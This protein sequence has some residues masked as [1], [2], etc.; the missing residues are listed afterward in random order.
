MIKF[1][2]IYKYI[3]IAL[4]FG[5]FGFIKEYHVPK[6][7]TLAILQVKKLTDKYIPSV[8][9]LPNDIEFGL[10]PPE[11]KFK[12][13]K[14]HMKGELV[15]FL[16]PIRIENLSIRLKTYSLLTGNYYQFIEININQPNF[17]VIIHSDDTTEVGSK[18]LPTTKDFINKINT[19]INPKVTKFISDI[20]I[21]NLNIIDAKITMEDTSFDFLSKINRLNLNIKNHPKGISLETY[22]R[23]TLFKRKSVNTFLKNIELDFKLDLK[24]DILSLS[25]VK[26]QHKKSFIISKGDISFNL[27]KSAV[28]KLNVKARTH[29][30]LASLRQSILT[31]F[32][33]HSVPKINGI[34][35]SEFNYGL[36]QKNL[37]EVTG[38]FEIKNLRINRFFVGNINTQITVNNEN[39]YSPLLR[40]YNNSGVID[41][42][43]INIQLNEEKNVKYTLNAKK[44]K[45]GA[46]LNNLGL[47]VST[48]SMM[49]DTDIPCDGVIKPSLLIKCNGTLN[50][51]DFSVISIK[52]E[53]D[54]VALDTF[55]LNGNVNI[56]S[57]KVVIKS[58]I[59][60]GESTKGKAEGLV[61]FKDG[62]DIKYQTESLN[63]K[64]VKSLSNL[65]IEG[66]TQVK[67]S[68]KGNSYGATFNMDLSTK[69]IWL[70]DYGLGNFQSHLSYKKG[71]LLF[72][73]VKGNYG[74]INFTGKT[75][76]DLNNETIDTNFDVINGAVHDLQ[77]LLSR[78]YD[79]P[80]DIYGNLQV[81]KAHVWGSFEFTKLN[82]DIN[83]KVSH[84]AIG[85]ETFDEF[86]FN[87]T[88]RKGIVKPNNILLR[89]GRSQ[90]T[91]QGIGN[92]DGNIDIKIAS[93]NFNLQDSEIISKLI[94]N[95][96]GNIHLELNLT[97]HILSPKT[98]LLTK[99]TNTYIGLEPL[100]DLEIKGNIT[101]ENI[102]GTGTFLDNTFKLSFI[103]PFAKKDPFKFYL[104]A[105]KWNFAPLFSIVSPTFNANEY[106]TE[107]TGIID[108]QSQSGGFWKSSGI[109]DLSLLHIKRGD[110][111]GYITKPTKITF[112]NG[113]MDIGSLN[114]KGDNTSLEV[115]AKNSRQ[116]N[117]NFNIIGKIEMGL[118]AFMTPFLSDLKGTLSLNFQLSGTTSEPQ[119]R[120][121]AM[122]QNGFIQVPDLVHPFENIQSDILFNQKKITVNTF[123]SNFASGVVHGNGSIGIKGFKKFPTN[124][125]GEFNN[126]N[127]NF[128]EKVE[129]SGSG[130]FKISG[131]W[132]PFTLTSH[133]KIN[134]GLIT[135]TLE[136]AQ[137]EDF[138]LRRRDFLPDFLIET[139][140]SMFNLNITSIFDNNFYV[141]NS[142]VDTPIKGTVKIQGTSVNPILLGT[143]NTKPGG[144][145]FFKDIPFD[146]VNSQLKFDNPNKNNP[147]IY[148]EAN[149]RVK[150]HDISLILQ[151]YADNYKI[152]LNSQP[153]LAEQDIVS[154]LAL[155]ITTD[156]L[157]TYDSEEQITQQSYEIGSALISNNPLG[158]EIKK[159]Y[160][161]EVKFSSA[162]DDSN[163][164]NPKIIVSKKWS[165]RL[166]TSTS[167]TF[168]TEVKQDLKVQYQLNNN[169]SV[170][171]SWEGKEFTEEAEFLDTESENT[172]I[173]G[174]DLEYRVKFK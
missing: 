108:L 52:E 81:T 20:P 65:K 85:I 69:N 130:S 83:S 112:N 8:S 168:G 84:G 119:V 111:E 75:L 27:K 158:N 11:I 10:W 156:N 120:G 140:F 25:D 14:I 40:V 3:L 137:S 136:E 80:Y 63:F 33:E 173:L 19:V 74:N 49:I 47:D 105:N 162:I 9:F 62:F 128:P 135:K 114:I 26:F 23:D 79:F 131:Q 92:P 39:I 7:K 61:H 147:Y 55:L 163:T 30:E 145:I 116:N 98:E 48:L 15:H 58:D 99:I 123:L 157:E 53:T 132:F 88:A 107:F 21:A 87:I 50:G 103:F 35:K 37:K 91:L 125:Q 34:L 96:N 82:Y 12:S 151:G 117:L 78:K 106:Q 56:T 64:D 121:L 32:P 146:I 29:F 165:P 1:H 149:V 54:I 94:P 124:V 171:G 167:R 144:K 143:V 172:D 77:R 142:L 104:N 86:I 139:K 76:V 4:L 71:E 24:D 17:A 109:I 89:K 46:F 129:T 45:L 127:L 5:T 93:Q 66:E 60:I 67:G 18:G 36:D 166:S 2:A 51:N 95:L 134:R 152:N 100:P 150:N 169:L 138:Q 113:K 110:V 44:V 153:P 59:N 43:D 72:S 115:T 97:D 141:R 41:L 101:K 148:S 159:K 155:G 31:F 13:G 38:N 102:S 122:I 164:L 161:V 22:I 68:T 90:A 57:D 6:L 16:T 70:E 126:V 133:Y 174:L 160:G 42:K 170:I 118:L 28:E 154:L 73:K